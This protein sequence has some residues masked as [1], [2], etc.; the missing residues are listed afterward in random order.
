M[1]VSHI[2]APVCDTLIHTYHKGCLRVIPV[3]TE[4]RGVPPALQ[5]ADN[6][7]FA[8]KAKEDDATDLI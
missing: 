1:D 8:S 2:G 4:E 3:R 6:Y 7:E 5:A